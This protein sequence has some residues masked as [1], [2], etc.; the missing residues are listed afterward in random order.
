MR[1]S[2]DPRYI[3]VYRE[4]FPFDRPR[5]PSLWTAAWLLAAVIA[6]LAVGLL[7]LP[8]FRVG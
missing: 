3:P 7:L 8:L 4:L 1:S 6:I 5:R 2:T